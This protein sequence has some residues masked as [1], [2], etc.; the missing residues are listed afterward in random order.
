[1]KITK[2]FSR[3][4]FDCRDGTKYPEEW[5]DSRLKP[6]CEALEELREILGNVPITI[7]SGYRT[8]SHNRKV[9]GVK[10]SQHVH[11]RAAD[12]MCKKESTEAIGSLLKTLMDDGIIPKG[13]VGIYKTFV[14]YD[15]RGRKALWR[16]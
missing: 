15:I 5:I 10:N 14:H 4:E 9:G 1:M 3:Q 8:P 2:H 7:S 12:I 13:G 11:G 16:G 6:L